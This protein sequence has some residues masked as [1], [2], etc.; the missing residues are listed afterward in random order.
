LH[1]LF[2]ILGLLMSFLLEDM[3]DYPLIDV[4]EMNLFI[5]IHRKFY[6]LKDL[7]GI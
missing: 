6:D 7:K 4:T 1:Q 3:L 5:L 2:P